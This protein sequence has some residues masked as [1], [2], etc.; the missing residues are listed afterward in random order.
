MIKI[1][2]IENRGRMSINEMRTVHLS[3]ELI[4]RILAA[5][6]RQQK[7]A[8]S[9]PQEAKSIAREIVKSVM[10]KVGADKLGDLMDKII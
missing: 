10:I 8:A 1:G 5:N 3:P 7:Q 9:D 4:E 2:K 6:N